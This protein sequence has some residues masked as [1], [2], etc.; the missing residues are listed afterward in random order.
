MD[1]VALLPPASHGAAGDDG[2]MTT[3]HDVSAV[4]LQ[5]GYV[6]KQCPVRAQNDV[7]RPAEP[8]PTP[9]ALQRRFQRGIDFEADVMTELQ[10]LHPDAVRIERVESPPREAATLAAMQA[11]AVL[12]LE[13]RLP[14]DPVGRRAGEPDVLVAADGGGYRAV[15]VK[16][17]RTVL[18]LDE[19]GAVWAELTDPTRERAHADADRAIQK[20]KSDLLQLAHYQRMLEAAGLA[21]PDGRHGAI[22]GTEQ[23]VVWYDLD[24]PMWRTPSV[25]ER[26]KVRST[27]E[28]YDFEFA[29]RLDTIAVAREHLV[30]PSVEPLLVPVRISE[31]PACPWWGYCRTELEA[32]S[33]DVSLVPRVGWREWDVYRRFGVTDRAGLAALD[34]RTAQLRAQKVD[35]ADLIAKCDGLPSETPMSDVSG[36]ARRPAQLATLAA[37]GVNTVGDVTQLSPSTAAFPPLPSLPEQIDQARAALG[38]LA[39]YRRRGVE[40]LFVPRGD[41]EVDVDMENVEEGVYLW[42]TLVSKGAAH[43][44]ESWMTWE[45]LDPDEQAR[46]FLEFWT[47]LMELRA[48]AHASRET[49]RAYCYS[50]TAENRFLRECGATLGVLTDVEAFIASEEWVDMLQVFDSQ[51][52]T[53]GPSGLKVVAPLAG[54]TWGVDDPGGAESMLRYDQAVGAGSSGER[55]EARAWLLEYNRGDVEAT[56]AIRDWMEEARIPS[57]ES[58]ERQERADESGLTV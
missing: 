53:G 12:I 7:L 24:E 33:G 6:A 10:R 27:M 19:G 14:G 37:G 25:S 38:P 32:G 4:P 17:H 52:I 3:R 13:G 34:V 51:L 46:N 8:I 40:A 43:R 29:F 56:R 18:D 42:G 39:V 16:H 31:C 2:S 41:I 47:R 11:G 22:I 54:F 55:E 30:D 35:V 20:R 9:P 28:V 15:D 58:L 26:T 21:A 57:V 50:E 36:M 48:A 1:G 5:G 44:Y 23:K 49:F 45:P